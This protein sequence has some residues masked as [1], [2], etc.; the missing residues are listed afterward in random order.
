MVKFS[1][2]E[3]Q[4]IYSQGKNIQYSNVFHLPANLVPYW[5]GEILFLET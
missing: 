2:V 5:Q 3:A 1:S 4:S